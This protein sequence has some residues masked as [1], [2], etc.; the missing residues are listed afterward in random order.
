MRQIL[1]WK[2]KLLVL[3]VFRQVEPLLFTYCC[4]CRFCN[5]IRQ[6]N[7]NWLWLE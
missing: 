6:S 2:Q 4:C 1:I 3:V 7:N 5:K